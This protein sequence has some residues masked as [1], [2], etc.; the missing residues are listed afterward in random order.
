MGMQVWKK[1]VER[2]V[3]EMDGDGKQMKRV[4]Q[5]GNE[6]TILLTSTFTPTEREKERRKA[7]TDQDQPTDLIHSSLTHSLFNHEPIQ[8][9]SF[10]LVNE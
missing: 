6:I 1:N 5:E 2:I 3:C 4:K 8:P 7:T 9:F 10:F